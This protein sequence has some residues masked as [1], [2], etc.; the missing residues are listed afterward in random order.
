MDA[1][2]LDPRA[3]AALAELAACHPGRLRLHEGDAAAFDLATLAPAPRQIVANLPY[4][5]GTPLLVG[6][7][8]GAG[9]FERLTLMF[10]RE[11]AE[12]ITAR[13]G[14]DAYGRLGVLANWIAATAIVA[15]IPPGAFYPPPR[16]HSAVVSLV[17]RPDQPTPALFAAMERVTAAAFGQRRKM[18]RSSLKPVGGAALLDAAAIEGDRRAETLSVAEFERLAALHLA[19]G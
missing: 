12:R 2:E 17:P 13:V 6:W 18:L 15:E 4:N 10:Q 3:L 8:R 16:I 7:L 5:V 14:D 19:G 11:V 1:I 9:A